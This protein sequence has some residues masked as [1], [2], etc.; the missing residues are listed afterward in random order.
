MD[1]VWK[2]YGYSMEILWIYTLYYGNTVDIVWKY[3]G[4]SMKILWI[5]SSMEILRIYTVLWKYCGY[6]MEIL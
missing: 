4:Y 6:S 3:Y 5:Y 1:I 2:Y